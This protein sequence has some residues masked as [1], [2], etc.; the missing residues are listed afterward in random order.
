MEQQLS[1]WRDTVD[2][3]HFAVPKVVLWNRKQR[4]IVCPIDGTRRNAEGEFT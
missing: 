3:I 1:M 2:A 4:A